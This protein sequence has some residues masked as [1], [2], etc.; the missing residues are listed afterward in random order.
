M[1]LNS[2]FTYF[3]ILFF[4]PIIGKLVKELID[5][6]KLLKKFKSPQTLLSLTTR[7]TPKEFKL[8]C[9]DYL[10]DLGYTTIPSLKIDNDN[11]IIC[12]KENN[13]V[14]V[15]CK[16]YNSNYIVPI[17]DFE[18][19]FGSMII[20]N[21]NVGLLITTGKVSNDVNELLNKLPSNF[22][23]D[24]IDRDALNYPYEKYILQ[25]T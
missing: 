21:I 6:V 4:S 7:L 8:W 16:Q 23:I 12:K 1:K 22:H 10:N 13:S 19:L 2:V 18:E 24:I 14:Y 25:D 9:T 17:G 20:N 5:Y 3:L 15:Q 11:N